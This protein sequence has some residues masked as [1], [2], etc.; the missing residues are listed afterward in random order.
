MKYLFTWNSNFLINEAVNKWKQQFISKYWDF[1]MIH[2]KDI[3]ENDVNYLAENILAQ[4][5]L[6]EKKLIVL[7]IDK[8]LKEQYIDFLT[9]NLEN[10]PP[11]NIILV[12]YSNPDKRQKFYKFLKEKFDV[13]E[14]NIENENET[15]SILKNKYGKNIDDNAIRKII[16]YKSNNISK[17]ESEINKLLITYENINEKVVTDNIIPELEESIFEIIDNILNLETNLAIKKINIIL[18]Q[19][20]IYWFYNNLIANIRTNIYIFKLKKE[21]L[22]QSEITNILNLWNRWFLINKRYKINYS[23]LSKLYIRLIDIDKKMKSWKLIGTEESDFQFELEKE[24]LKTG[25]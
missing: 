3:N 9:N 2:I 11:E 7:D 1:N 17:I 4:S 12:S 24:L 18:N 6:A 25:N 5:F 16:S 10:I 20:N 21:W 19:T 14:F 15:F 23:N 22:N 8:D 13:K